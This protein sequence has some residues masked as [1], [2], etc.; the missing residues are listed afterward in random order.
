M[1]V[2]HVYRTYFPDTQGGLEETVRQICS[3]TISH[4]VE[5]R[6]FT[7]SQNPDPAIL[8]LP[9]ADVFRFPLTLEIASCGFSLKGLAGFKKLLKWADIIHYH[10]PWPFADLL[11]LL[12]RVK[13]PTV[14]S[15]QADII[16]QKGLLKIYAPLQRYFL[17]N[18]SKIITTSPNYLQTSTVLSALDKDIEIIPNGL[19]EN[20]YPVP[21]KEKLSEVQERYGTD[22]FLFVGVLRYYKG[23]K[24]L[25]DASA[26]ADFTVVI[27]GSGPMERDLKDQAKQLGLDNV[28]FLGYVEDD[29]KIALIQGARAIVFPSCERS[30]AFGMT[31]VEGAMYSKPLITAEIGSGTSYVNR[32]LETGIVVAPK[33]KVSLREAM[34]KIYRDDDFAIQMGVGA[35]QR[36][37]ALFT[38]QEMGRKYV[39]VYRGL[40]GSGS[41]T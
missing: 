10:Y 20:G 15:Y 18:V 27:A 19:N 6:I 13:K 3:N 38:G 9:E 2:L 34:E 39:D 7:L 31:L 36:Y 22:Y 41:A 28:K 16:R 26:G 1:R 8:Q 35:R 11:H 40:M 30:E 29:E 21:P 33:D 12:Y 25:L 5:H 37:E 32:H 14:V 4:G 17:E 24:Y 23:L